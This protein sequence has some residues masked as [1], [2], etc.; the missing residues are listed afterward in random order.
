[1][2]R[3]ELGRLCPSALGWGAN[4]IRRVGEGRV[5]VQLGLTGSGALLTGAVTCMFI[6]RAAFGRARQTVW[7]E[8]PRITGCAERRRRS[9]PSPGPKSQ[10]VRR[11]QV[12]IGLFKREGSPLPCGSRTADSCPEDVPR[13][14][15]CG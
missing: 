2:S 8:S 12:G 14:V 6:L 4:R 5:G 13:T 15:R 10:L 9:C 7:A 1:M 3:L 11:E